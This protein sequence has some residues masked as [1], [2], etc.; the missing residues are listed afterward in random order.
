MRLAKSRTSE[1]VP[2]VAAIEP[3]ELSAMFASSRRAKIFGS[4]QVPEG[5]GATAFVDVSPVTV[6]DAAAVV[7][8]PA[9]SFL[10]HPTI[11]TAAIAST[12]TLDLV[13]F[14][15][16]VTLSLPI[17]G[18]RK[19]PRRSRQFV[20]AWTSQAKSVRITAFQL[21]RSFA[22]GDGY[23][24]PGEHIPVRETRERTFDIERQRLE[25]VSRRRGHA[26]RRKEY[27]SE[28]V[29][30]GEHSA[31]ADY[32]TNPMAHDELLLRGDVWT[33]ERFLDVKHTM[34]LS[35]Q[36]CHNLGRRL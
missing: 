2:F 35:H 20:L 22:L 11:A 21:L 8:T 23:G 4:V 13:P 3:A 1:D 7:S 17:S 26:H 30:A 15:N 12:V 34:A 19:K 36:L 18:V 31:K 10:A 24:V 32:G 16:I 25:S 33:A 29:A 6:L 5:A 9:F 27:D 14:I 28:Q